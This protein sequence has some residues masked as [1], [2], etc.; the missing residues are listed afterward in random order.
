MSKLD[1]AR[2]AGWAAH[3]FLVPCIEAL[4]DA[5][6]EEH[7]AVEHRLYGDV[8]AHPAVEMAADALRITIVRPCPK[9]TPAE[10][11]KAAEGARDKFYSEDTR[12]IRDALEAGLDETATEAALRLRSALSASE[13]RVKVL[14]VERAR[15]MNLLKE[16][17]ERVST[18]LLKEVAERIGRKGGA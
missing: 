7:R 2:K 1:A 18:K 8:R 14:E 12:Q 11:A 16:L 5:K 10:P 6:I 9:C 4:I 15:D 3:E 17:A 13:A